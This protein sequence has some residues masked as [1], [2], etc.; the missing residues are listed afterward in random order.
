VGIVAAPLPW[1]VRHSWPRLSPRA[2]FA[3]P[4]DLLAVIKLA[5]PLG[6]ANAPGWDGW[7]QLFG[8]ALH[9][10]KV[11]LHLILHFDHAA[12]DADGLDSEIRLFDGCV[13]DIGVSIPTNA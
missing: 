12:S 10:L 13:A 1:K 3:S 4:D 11:D 7:S 8:L 9:Y 6:P 2:G 5:F